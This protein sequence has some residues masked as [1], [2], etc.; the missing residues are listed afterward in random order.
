[1]ETDVSSPRP[2]SGQDAE[3]YAA[4][5]EP[6]HGMGEQ[7]E[8]YVA[9]RRLLLARKAAESRLKRQVRPFLVLVRYRRKSSLV[10]C[11]KGGGEVCFE[12]PLF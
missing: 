1:M 9:T 6:A 3:Y 12:E 5:L 10:S 11:L 4:L 7:D 2:A 8:F